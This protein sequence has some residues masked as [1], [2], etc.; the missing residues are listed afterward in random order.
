MGSRPGPGKLRLEWLS[1]L[2]NL[3]FFFVSPFN[4][5][6]NLV[7]LLLSSLGSLYNSKYPVAFFA[8]MTRNPNAIKKRV[9]VLQGVFLFYFSPAS[10]TIM[11][12]G[13]I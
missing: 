4:E 6:L 10:S 2:Y 5:G 9:V 8:S 1:E 3:D 12:G 13:E 7:G 11:C